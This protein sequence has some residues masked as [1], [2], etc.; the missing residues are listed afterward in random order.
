MVVRRL[1]GGNWTRPRAL[2]SGA[3]FLDVAIAENAI[4]DT[5]VAYALGTSLVAVTRRAGGRWGRPHTIAS[6]LDDFPS[7]SPAMSPRGTATVAFVRRDR[8][9]AAVH[10]RSGWGRL[11]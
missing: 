3:Y 2:D 4:G 8:V 9:L 5:V 10:H 1:P 11:N 7:L 6:G